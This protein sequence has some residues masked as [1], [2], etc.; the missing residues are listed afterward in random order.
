[1]ADYVLGLDLGSNS[2]GWAMI[3]QNGSFDNGKPIL[4]GARVF[5]EGVAMLN[6]AK[7]KP[8]GQDRRMARGMRRM[9]QRRAQ[10]QRGLLAVLR[11]VGILNDA[12][13]VSND[14][15]YE[16][17]KLGLDSALSAA[18]FARA[19]LAL[20]K[21]RGFKS[22]RKQAK[23]ADDGKVAKE[24][25]ILQAKIHE[26]G[27]RTLGEYLCDL[28]RQFQHN[29][30]AA[31]RVRNRYTLRS[32]YDM[33]FDLLWSAQ[34]KH[35]SGLLTDEIK[36]KVRHAIFFQ[37]PL[38]SKIDTI[39]DCE[40]EPGE[41]RCPRAHWLGQQFRLL[42]EINLLKV[43][44]VGGEERQLKDEERSI[45]AKS[46]APKAQMT[47]DDIRQLLGF[48][49]NQKFNLEDLSKRNHL[50]G[51]QIEA[52]L[53]KKPLD[54]WY[55]ALDEATRQ[56][57]YEA[58]AEEEDEEKLRQTAMTQWGAT[59]AQA[60]KLIAITLP[61][62]YFQVSLK[63]IEKMMPHL[64][65]G[66]VYSLAKERAGYELGASVSV[67]DKLPPV[68]EVLKHLTNPLVHRALGEARKVVNS[69]VSRHGKPTRIVIELARDMKHSGQKR[70]ELFYEN[71][72][73]QKANDDIRR[74]I[75]AEFNIA[76]PSRDDV[77]KYKLW[78]ECGCVCP[79]TGRPIPPTKLFTGEVQI[80][81]ILPY[82]RT[83]DDSFMNKS[84]CYEDAN[85]LKHNR[86]PVE[87]YGQTPKVY[88]EILLR[89]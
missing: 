61:P 89:V 46:L 58:L 63:A 78:Q 12:E 75:T 13:S 53:S 80:E 64:Q 34:S 36:E 21:R 70:K 16:L 23:G 82:S 57:V 52:A 29:D 14:N 17:R 15:P 39:G 73:R 35:H 28:D 38:K 66:C 56:K 68:D 42:Q 3:S 88:E 86:T 85:R 32:M 31:V 26:A 19:L 76:S 27:A 24:T 20:C 41:K 49:D 6:T 5:P 8:R 37:R 7:E 51:N 81:H 87:A 9:H 60:Q 72:D 59:E 71:L 43:L 50:K 77:L 55:A 10:R 83:L 84:L 79:Y 2:V 30:P 62:G 45:L 67:C 4:A 54:K 18:Q 40:L 74:R 65:A 48:Q 47:F 33:E 44:D 25:T 69:I 22:N 11:S 1:M